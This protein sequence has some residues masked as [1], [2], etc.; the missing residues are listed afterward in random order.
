MK[1]IIYTLNENLNIAKN[2]IYDKIY[3]LPDAI[4]VGEVHTEPKHSYT[5]AKLIKKYK[6]EYVLMEGFNDLPPEKTQGLVNLFKGS[7][8]EKIAGQYNIDLTNAGISE[9]DLDVA[10]FQEKF[11]DGTK[12][13]ILKNYITPKKYKDL[14]ETPLYKL[15]PAVLDNILNKIEDK[16]KEYNI[17]GIDAYDTDLNNIYKSIFGFEKLKYLAGFEELRDYTGVVLDAIAEVDAKLAG[18]DINK[19]L[20][21]LN[22][23]GDLSET[24]FFERIMNYREEIHRYCEENNPIREQTMG[25][26]IIEYVDKKEGDSPIITIIGIEHA[27]KDSEIHKVLNSENIDYRIITPITINKDPIEEYLYTLRLSE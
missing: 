9:D 22:L 3:G 18:C 10:Y 20:P 11:D 6:P 16:M 14:L 26:K 13:Y 2:T 15:H 24:E 12:S 7:T 27:K 21:K 4:I 19:K 23:E 1:E 8:L 5:E 25:N 17:K